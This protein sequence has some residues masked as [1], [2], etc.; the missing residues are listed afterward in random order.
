M[1]MRSLRLTVLMMG[2][3]LS[4]QAQAELVVVV[5]PANP[6]DSLSRREVVDLYM[7]RTQYFADGNLVLRLDQPPE[8][9]NRKNFY[10]GLVNRTVAEVN[11]YWAKL[12]FTGRASPPQVVSDSDAVRRAVSRNVNAIG[13]LDSADVDE[14]V[15]VVARVH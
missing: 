13:Y 1:L 9:E 8:S 12:L 5:H 4:W 14:T 15:K 7:G 6:A 10:R 2:L 11:A 3:L